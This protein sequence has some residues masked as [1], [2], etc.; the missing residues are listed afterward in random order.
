MK[1]NSNQP[2]TIRTLLIRAT[3]NLKPNSVQTFSP[4]ILYKLINDPFWVWCNYHVPE[5][6]KVEEIDR[7]DELRKQ[8]GI[9]YEEEWVKQHYPDAIKI[10]PEWGLDALKNTFK[11]MLNGVPAI[12]SPNLWLLPEEMYGKGDVFVRSNEAPSDLGPYHY[13]V[14]EIKRSKKLQSYHSLQA[15]VYNRML[16][17]IQGYT[18]PELS[19]VLA[20][21]EEKVPYDSKLLSNLDEHLSTWRQIRDGQFKPEPKGFDQ[22]ESP[23]RIYTNKVLQE[24][25]DLTLLPDVGP[26][27]RD[28]LKKQLEIESIRDLYSLSQEKFID[29]LGPKMG[30]WVYNSTQAYKHNKPLMAPGT[31]LNIPRG[32]RNFYFDFETSDDVHPTEH[33]H[34]YLIGVWDEDKDKFTYFLGRGAEDEPKIFRDFLKYLGNYEKDCLYHW[35]SFETETMEKE[36]IVRHPELSDE[37]NNLIKS[38]I[39]L[40]EVIKQQVYLPVPTYSVKSVAPALGFSWRQKEVNAFESMVLYWEY[41][42]DGDTKKIQKVL[43]YNEDDCLAML[44]IDR[45][46]RQEFK[47]K[48]SY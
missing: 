11:A 5:E 18:P 21:G 9:E 1:N 16:G 15:A 26:G 48:R 6:E 8:R 7:H 32:R 37:L 33:P 23:W 36:V 44:Y 2:V 29:V 27:T 3:G 19:V 30:S 10:E 43:D 40:K 4:S 25:M 12:H 22:T 28:K 20:E 41:L 13:R 38:C 47:A 34:V 35:H 24:S 45:K 31:T 17:K 42:K 46:L 14:K 39:D